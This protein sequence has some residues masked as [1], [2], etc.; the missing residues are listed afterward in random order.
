MPFV[1]C[2]GPGEYHPGHARHLVGQSD[3]DL[4]GVHPSLQA[5]QPVT[6]PVTALVEVDEAGSCAM[7]QQSPDIGVAE[8]VEISATRS[9]R[10]APAFSRK[11][12]SIREGVS[13]K[14]S[15]IIADNT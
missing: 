7:D 14:L 5:D 9:S 6:K 12:G 11:Q 2:A 8:A 4:V 15:V 1:K 13:I 10:S 3:R